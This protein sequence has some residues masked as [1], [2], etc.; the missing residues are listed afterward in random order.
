M[1]PDFPK[2]K[3]KFHEYFMEFFHQRHQQYLGIWKGG[4]SYKNHEGHIWTSES[5]EGSTEEHDYI[6]IDEKISVSMDDVP[7]LTPERLTIMLDELAHNI[8]SKTSKNAIEQMTQ[9]LEKHD[10]T[11]DGK[12]RALDGELFLDMLEFTAF[13]FDDE[14]N[15]IFP[16]LIA[17]PNVAE[18]L[19]RESKKWEQDPDFEARHEII[20]RQ[21]RLDWRDRESRRKLVN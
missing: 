6:S 20:I 13:D 5:P 1:L 10:R 18:G 8:A 21:K 4:A 16:S 14:G 3:D 11:L 17:H 15:P 9:W 2:Q 19:M 12:G 7:D